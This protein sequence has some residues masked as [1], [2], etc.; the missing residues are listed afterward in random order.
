M[1]GTFKFLR[2]IDRVFFDRFVCFIRVFWGFKA[3]E[4]QIL[5]FKHTA[6]FY[7]FIVALVNVRLVVCIETQYPDDRCN[8]KRNCKQYQQYLFPQLHFSIVFCSHF[9]QPIYLSR[10]SVT[11]SIYCAESLLSFC[12]PCPECGRI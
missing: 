6:C 1:I 3:A 5:C 9:Y 7:L 2:I 12:K 11:L 4:L 10:Y 8:H